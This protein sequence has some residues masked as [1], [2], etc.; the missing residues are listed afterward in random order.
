MNKNMKDSF[1]R[2]ATKVSNAVGG[3][4]VFFA[5]VF[6]VIAWAVTGP[7]F[8]YSNTWQLFINTGTT[9]CTFL[10]VFLIQSTQ[11]RDG[12]AMQLKLDE[13]LR[14]TQAA[15][16][17][18]VDL[19]QLTDDELAEL[20]AE[21]SSLHGRYADNP[22]ATLHKIHHKISEVRQ[23]RTKKHLHK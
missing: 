17:T 8:H 13:L 23:D 11:N 12:K 20:D 2:L 16:D 22:P 1:R 3:A 7:L 9:I 4:Y 6:F 21:F 14:V 19:E 15:R 18:F 10:M 5:A